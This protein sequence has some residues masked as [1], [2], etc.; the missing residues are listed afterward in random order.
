MTI[1]AEE[2]LTL[3]AFGGV[4]CQVVAG[5]TLHRAESCVIAGIELEELGLEVCR[6]PP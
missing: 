2:A 3:V 5:A 1:N 6:C 4:V